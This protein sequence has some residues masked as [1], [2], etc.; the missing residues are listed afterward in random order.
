MSSGSAIAAVSTVGY[1]G[2]LIVP[3]LIG[4]VAEIAGLQ[5][6]FGLM[7]AFGLVI[8][9]LVQFTLDDQRPLGSPDSA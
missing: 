7:A 3:P 2:F 5:W 4:S 8:T 9:G 1:F 6:S